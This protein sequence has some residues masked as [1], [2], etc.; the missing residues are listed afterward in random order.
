MSEKREILIG[1]IEAQQK[2]HENEPA[3]MVGEQLKEMADR[4]PA[5]VDLLV[6]DLQTGGMAL[7]DAAAKI[8]EYADKNRKGAN[9]FCVTPIVAE[10]ILRKFYGLPERAAGEQK[11]ADARFLDLSTFL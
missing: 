10:G 1:I 7:S 5:V 11:T 9:C 4:E 2:G 6:N 3:F 8:K